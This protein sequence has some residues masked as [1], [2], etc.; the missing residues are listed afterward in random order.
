MRAQLSSCVGNTQPASATYI[1]RPRPGAASTNAP[2]RTHAA[3]ALLSE[4]RNSLAQLLPEFMIPSAFVLLETLPRNASGKVEFAALPDPAS[5]RTA[6]QSRYAAPRTPLEQLIAN[7]Y[8][9]LLDLERAGRNDSFFDLGGHSLLATQLS[10]R[11]RELLRTDVPLR[12]IFEC[13]TVA[14]LAEWLVANEPR[15]GMM[16]A[17]AALRLKLEAMPEDQVLQLLSERTP[18]APSQAL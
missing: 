8:A 12:R 11:L 14:A 3:P 5:A 15:P 13:P 4:L 18:N 2:L 17:V 1:I 10:S 16:A 6:A 9:R 7:T